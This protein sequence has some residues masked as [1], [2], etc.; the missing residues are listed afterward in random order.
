MSNAIAID[1]GGTKI[2]AAVIDDR[3]VISKTIKRPT[4]LNG[5]EQLFKELCEIIDELH[6]GNNVDV[7]GIGSAGRINSING[8]VFWASDNLPGWTNFQIKLRIE[9]IYN[10]PCFVEN[11]CRVTGL[12]EEWLG[13]ARG[14]D[15]YVCIALGTGIGSAVKIDGVMLYGD[16]FSSGEVGHMMI[17]PGGRQCNCGLKGCFEQYCSGPS[18]VKTYN[19]LRE[20]QQVETGYEFFELVRNEDPIACKIL[21]K[22]TDDL[23]F[24]IINLA[25][26]LDPHLFILAG[27]LSETS[28]YWYHELNEKLKMF[29]DN[30]IFEIKV[31]IAELKGLSAMY[32]AAYYA[33]ENLKLLK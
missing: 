17:H 6:H 32:G 25:N 4:N 15:S 23:A 16:H 14:V 28:E 11:D 9:E 21:S 2:Q 31:K 26:V 20:N 8:S 27:G 13:S 33:F 3:A 5:P 12:G 22:F 7:I 1:I 19:V 10:I 30:N 29:N 18:L 24:A